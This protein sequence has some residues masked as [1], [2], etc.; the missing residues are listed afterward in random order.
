MEP[1]TVSQLAGV[2]A[3]AGS[4]LLIRMKKVNLPRLVGN[5]AL[6]GDAWEAEA[7]KIIAIKTG[8]PSLGWYAVGLTRGIQSVSA[9]CP[10]PGPRHTKCPLLSESIRQEAF[11]WET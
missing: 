8:T 9:W 3:F 5:P 10:Y 2:M 7:A 1:G 11:K 6:R 4:L